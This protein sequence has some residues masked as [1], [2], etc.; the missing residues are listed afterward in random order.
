MSELQNPLVSVLIPAYNHEA[1]V[2]EAILSVVNQTFGYENI[3]LIVA[4]DCSKDNTTEILKT[5]AA[6]YAFKL[7]LHT[8]NKG[9]VST[10]NELISLASGEYIASF[11][12]D[13]KLFLDR[14]ENQISIMIKNPDID[15]LVGDSV[16][17][18]EN[19]KTL[20]VISKNSDTSL[21]YYNFDDLF[22]R[23]RPGF[24]AG[25]AIYKRDLFERIG[26]YDPNY[27]IEDYYFWLKA[28]FN[29]AKIAKCN[30]PFLYYRLNS[31]SI[32][33]N[34][35]LMDDER[36]KILE[37]YK[38]H[39]NY[40]KAIQNYKINKLASWVFNSKLNVITHLI[41][42]PKL[43]LNR[44]TMKVVAMIFMPLPILKKKFPE[45]YFRYAAF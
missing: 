22:M 32:S 39:P 26:T 29:K 42:N 44:K 24:A 21:I 14:I 35:N 2:E 37:I 23:L 38:S 4:D 30:S 15:I 5:L 19:G 36:I 27:L 16:L 43:L 3:E 18:D 25:T 1:W 28:T 11:A 45:K 33:S 17:M 20:S 7:V 9:L 6:T 40:Y 10:I 41:L 34:V 31:N 12:S 8:Q 13:D